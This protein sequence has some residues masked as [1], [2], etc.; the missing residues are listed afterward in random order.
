MSKVQ[1]INQELQLDSVNP[2]QHH[3]TDQ[4][5]RSYLP[6]DKPSEAWRRLSDLETENKHIVQEM[7]RLADE[8]RQTVSEPREI[9]L[10]VQEVR[11]RTVYIRW[12]RKGVKGKQAYLLLNSIDGREF[13]LRQSKQVQKLLVRFDQW[14]LSL[15]LAHS[16]RLLESKRIRQ[17]LDSLS[18]PVS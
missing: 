3:L 1:P 5:I 18:S 10:T 9:Y 17:Y 14:A 16:L 7:R 4:R 8:F 15:N 13:L 2:Y 12:R 6:F 11:S